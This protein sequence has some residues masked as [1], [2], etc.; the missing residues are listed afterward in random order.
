MCLLNSSQEHQ[1]HACDHPLQDRLIRL[2]IPVLVY[3]VLIWPLIMT[4]NKAAGIPA[5]AASPFILLQEM[6]YRETWRWLFANFKIAPGP[7]W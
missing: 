1:S 7:T 6:S 2:L 3:A 5:E 4:I